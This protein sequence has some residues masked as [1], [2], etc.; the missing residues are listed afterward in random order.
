MRMWHNGAVSSEGGLEG[1]APATSIPFAVWPVGSS[2]VTGSGLVDP[3]EDLDSSCVRLQLEG[4]EPRSTHAVSQHHG[5]SCGAV[6]A[7]PEFVFSPIVSD[8]QGKAATVLTPR[9]PFWRWWNRPHF[10]L[11]HWEPGGT[12]NPMA[13]GEIVPDPALR[14]QDAPPREPFTAAVQPAPHAMPQI[15]AALAGSESH[16]PRPAELTEREVEVLGLIATGASTSEIAA[17]LTISTN[18]VERHITNLYAK[19]GARNRSDATAYALRHGLA[20]V[21]RLEG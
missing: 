8:S 12:F 10:I 20:G 6:E 4:L 2:R 3:G 7:S 5:E 18:T 14:P 15:G 11:V 1:S 13:C 16:A 17:A 21:R 9:K 19:L